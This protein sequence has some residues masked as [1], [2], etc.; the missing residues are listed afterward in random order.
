MEVFKHPSSVNMIRLI[1]LL[2]L[3]AC[4]LPPKRDKLK[5]L[6]QLQGV[7]IKAIPVESAEEAKNIMNNKIS[8][9][10]LLFQQSTDPYFGIPKWTSQCLEANK[11]GEIISTSKGISSRSRLVLLDGNT[12]FCPGQPGSSYHEVIQF[13]CLSTK[14]VTE[15][16][17]S[18][19]WSFP[20]KEIDPCE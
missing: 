5:E 3:I 4:Q 13:H 15:I 12:G 2:V 14:E 9:L 17:Y 16:S 8:F 18:I 19:S 10:K 7:S 20:D 11:I 1:L 6:R